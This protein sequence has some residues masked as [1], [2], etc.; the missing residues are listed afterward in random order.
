M[1]YSHTIDQID[2]IFESFNVY[3]CLVIYDDSVQ[4]DTI[5]DIM[6]QKEYTFCTSSNDGRMYA[7]HVD[8]FDDS[9]TTNALDLDKH[10][11]WNSINMVLC[12]G[13]DSYEIGCYLSQANDFIEHVIKIYT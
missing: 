13:E 11:D 6:T 5:R 10:I 7:L 12:M 9:I 2:A 1:A 3:R 8:Y 4:F